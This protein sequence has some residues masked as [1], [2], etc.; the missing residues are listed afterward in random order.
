ML[1]LVDGTCY[2]L[3]SGDRTI[4]LEV[5]ACDGYP[6]TNAH[7]GYEAPL[8]FLIMEVIP[9]NPSQSTYLRSIYVFNL[10]SLSVI[11]LSIA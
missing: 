7:T 11:I 2:G 9:Q 5:D 4:R 10:Q 8:S 6:A 1:F 3:D